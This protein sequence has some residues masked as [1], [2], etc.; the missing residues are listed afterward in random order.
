MRSNFSIGSSGLVRL[1]GDL[2]QDGSARGA[3]ASL[4]T[5]QDFAEK[6]SRWVGVF[7]AGALHAVQQSAAAPAS[8]ASRAPAGRSIAPREQLLQVRAIL[9]R[10]ITAR[11]VADFGASR[12]RQQLDAGGPALVPE[13][14][15]APYRKRYLDQQ[16]N[17]DLMI[18]PLRDSLRQTLSAASPELRQLAAL[19]AVWEQMLAGREQ[20]LLTT[21]PARL[22]RRFDS[23]RKA[24]EQQ[25]PT[26]H[27]SSPPAAALTGTE[28]AQH[29]DWTEVFS[30]ELQQVLLA[31][32]EVRLEP[33]TGLIEAFEFEQEG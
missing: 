19:D 3:P 26:P 13:V 27:D 31:E 14:D 22:K 7:E 16:R 6:L 10:G 23:L 30:R 32:L 33:A 11:E 21:V 29:S 1:L 15:F 2:D 17:M 25:Q 4:A 20:K 8:G 18:G 9:A 28:A 12:G 5:A 24:H